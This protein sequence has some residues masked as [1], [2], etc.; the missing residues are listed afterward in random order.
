LIKENN[1]ILHKEF[2]KVTRYRNLLYHTPHRDYLTTYPPDP[3]P[4]PR[5]GGV[6]IERGEAPL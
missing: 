5:E 1:E 6:K 4:L 2:I 3:L